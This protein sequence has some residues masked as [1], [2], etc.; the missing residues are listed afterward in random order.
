[1]ISEEYHDYLDIF[2]KIDSNTLF[3]Y[4]EYHHKIHQKEK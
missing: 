1:M 2:S 3:L 4:Q